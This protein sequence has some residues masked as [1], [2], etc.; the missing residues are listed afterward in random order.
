[1]SFPV[2][3]SSCLLGIDCRYDGTHS[4]CEQVIKQAHEIRW[5][6]ICPEQMGGLPTPRPPSN[7][8]NGDGK[9]VLAGEARVI[10]SLGEDVTD[11]FIKGGRECLKLAKITGAKKAI[12]KN[13]SPAC[14]LNTPYCETDT[15]HG[16]GVTAALLLSASIE[17][18]E[19]GPEEKIRI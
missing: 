15:G 4:R 10:N 9:G 8:V 7:I 11:A 16:L 14:G 12:L 3:I 6:P 2:L 19:I 18:I 5:I 13:K 17:V 1:M